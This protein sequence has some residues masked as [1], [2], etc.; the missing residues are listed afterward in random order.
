[1]LVAWGSN[2]SGQCNVPTPPPGIVYVEAV[3][4]DETGY[5]YDGHTVARRSD[6]AVVAWGDNQYSECAVPVMP[7]GVGCVEI[8]AAYGLTILRTGPPTRYGILGYGCAGSGRPPRLVPFETPRI[9]STL[10]VNLLDLP[11]NAAFMLTGWSSTNSSFGPLP[12]SLNSLGMPGCIAFVS[13]DS[14]AIVVGAGGSA[15]WSTSIPD[16]PILV[17]LTFY[18]QAIVIDPLAG[19]SMGAVMSDAATAIVGSR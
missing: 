6:G 7:P 1:V 5:G 14:A 2:N 9:G 18:Q 8:E 15:L 17:G 11:A 12:L 10:R 4:A 16:L 19:N 3:A 13:A